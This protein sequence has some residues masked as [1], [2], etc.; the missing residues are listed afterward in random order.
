MF[1]AVFITVLMFVLTTGP[2]GAVGLGSYLG[3]GSNPVGTV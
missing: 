2:G 3:T 1:S